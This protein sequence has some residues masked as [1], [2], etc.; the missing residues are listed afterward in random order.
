MLRYSI[1]LLIHYLTCSPLIHN[2]IQQCRSLLAAIEDQQNL[3]L[4]VGKL[5]GTNGR[6]HHRHSPQNQRCIPGKH[7]PQSH[8]P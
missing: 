2:S 4:L 6:Q 8:R 7:T 3:V 5:I 1:R